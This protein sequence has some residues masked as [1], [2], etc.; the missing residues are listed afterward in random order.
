[1][2]NGYFE[3]LEYS[4]HCKP[5]SPFFC[6]H[7]I[8]PITSGEKYK[9][10]QASK[11]FPSTLS[12]NLI[13]FFPAPQKTSIRHIYVTR[14]NGFILYIFK[15]Q[16]ERKNIVALEASGRTVKMQPLS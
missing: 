13:K 6:L 5:L 15:Q 14:D 4:I 10:L 9:L 8:T 7:F 16:R 1:V 3:T 11:C 2:K 12:P